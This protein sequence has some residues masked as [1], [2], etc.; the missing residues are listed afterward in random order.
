MPKRSRWN[1][2]AAL[3]AV[4]K[5][6][7]GANFESRRTLY[8]I[9][10]AMGTAE[11]WGLVMEGFFD[12]SFE[13][14]KTAGRALR[15]SVGIDGNFDL[16]RRRSF[17]LGEVDAVGDVTGDFRPPTRR[18]TGSAPADVLLAGACGLSSAL[19]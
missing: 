7:A 14:V 1:R 4:R 13:M 3:P 19:T 2:Q 18:R 9:L 5:A 17:R 12:D 16:A 8:G 10:A 15:Q 6:L 11:A